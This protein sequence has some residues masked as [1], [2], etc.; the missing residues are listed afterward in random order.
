MGKKLTLF[1]ALA[2]LVGFVLP[3][4]AEVQNVKVSGD[5]SILGIYRD[6]Y[7]LDDRAGSGSDASDDHG[8]YA[9]ITRLRVD[10]DLTDNVQA[11]VRLL[12]ERTW[13]TESAEST[14]VDLDLAYITLKEMLYSPLTLILGRQN[15]KFGTG[16]IV[17]DPDTNAGVGVGGLNGTMAEDLSARKAFDALRATLDYAPWTIDL[18]LAKIDETEAAYGATPEGEDEDLYGVNVGYKFGAY[19]AEAEAY[20]FAKDSDTE[21]SSI[22]GTTVNLT[23]GGDIYNFGLRG[24]VEPIKGLALSGEV[25]LQRGDAQESGGTSRDQKAWALDLDGSYTWDVDFAPSIGLGYS[26]RSGEES[27]NSGDF[28]AWNPMY[29]DQTNGIVADYIFSGVNG[30]VNSNAQII[31]VY[32]SIKPTKDITLAAKYYNYRLDEKLVSSD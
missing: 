7:D 27:G 10:A 2:M 15:L 4:F 21:I 25:A 26:F 16:L 3:A 18:I 30:G 1:L 8:F 5:I 12:N 6:E 32:G 20:F 23:Q 31:K 22:G 28:E 29:E 9:S 24:S 14:D 17:G 19:N 11:T 13:D